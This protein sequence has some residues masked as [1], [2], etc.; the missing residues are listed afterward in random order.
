[1]T[2]RLIAVL[3]LLGVLTAAPIHADDRFILLAS[4][5]STEN[6][7]LF[8]HLIPLFT[9][10]TGI[11]VRVVAVGTGQAFAIARNGDADTV[12]VHDTAGEENMVAEGYASERRDVMYNDYVVV[13]PA[14]DPAGIRTA[15]SAA[16]AF[17]RIAALQTPFASR[18]DDSGTHR[19]EQRIWSQAGIAPRGTWY[20]ELG[21]GMGA[22]LNTAA[23]MDAYVLA[24]RGTWI[25]FA[26]RQDLELLYAGDP[27][28]FNQYGSLRLSAERHP[29][30]KHELAGR[31]HDWL[32]SADGQAAIAGF[33][34]NG[35][36]L[37]FPT[38]G[39]D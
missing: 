14:N 36:Q 33:K 1:M 37:F 20:R 3:A 30:L 18:G 24:D 2:K 35:E 27:A 23:A 19:A 6:S 25:S 17:K 29:H 5:T 7:G 12:L 8:A 11:E 32:L 4:T 28:L 34:L 13:G 15:T 10:A 22:A 21:S 38:A 9:A 26:N 31:W 39:K 16:D